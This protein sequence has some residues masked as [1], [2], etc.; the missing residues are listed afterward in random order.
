M[1]FYLKKLF[2][3]YIKQIDYKK[4]QIQLKI[5]EKKEEKKPYQTQIKRK[6]F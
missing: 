6:F 3:N 2:F 5:Y 4:S 1:I